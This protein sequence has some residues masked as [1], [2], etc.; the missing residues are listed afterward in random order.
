[1]GIYFIKIIQIKRTGRFPGINIKIMTY[2][3]PLTI[4]AILAVSAGSIYAYNI[5]T[6][7]ERII[8]SIRIQNQA[9]EEANSAKI[10][11]YR[12]ILDKCYKSATGSSREILE[13]LDACKDLQKP[14][15]QMIISYSGSIE[16]VSKR[17]NNVEESTASGSVIPVPL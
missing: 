6:P 2:A 7:E 1:M 14:E 15:L 8:E 4:L 5:K 12:A 3:R 13:K 17:N 9:I 16:G 11:S 10:D